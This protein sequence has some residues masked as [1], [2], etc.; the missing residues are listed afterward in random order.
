MAEEPAPHPAAGSE[1][2]AE[3]REEADEETAAFLGAGEASSGWGGEADLEPEAAAFSRRAAVGLAVAIYGPTIVVFVARSICVPVLPLFAR[4]TLG[5]SDS[6]V[7]LSASGQGLGSIFASAGSGLFIGHC[8]YEV[9]LNTGV[10]AM[11]VASCLAGLAQH[12]GLLVL[13][14]VL[15]GCGWS[16]FTVSLQ[17]RLRQAIPGSWRGRAMS[18][19]GGSYRV[20]YLTGPLIGAATAKRLNSLRAVFFLQAAMLVCL[21]AVTTAQ[22]LVGWQRRKRGYGAAAAGAGGGEGKAEKMPYA[23]MLRLTGKDLATAGVACMVIQFFRASRDLVLPLRGDDLNLGVVEVGLVVAC[24]AGADLL[25]FPVS[26]VLMDKFGRK[27]AMVPSFLV[28]ALS[29]ATT[30]FAGTKLTLAFGGV[31][32]G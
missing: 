9:G 3:G 12:V 20:G 6:L 28:F 11:M 8:G 31:L 22:A 13:G 7:G 17:T 18:F 29:M 15:Y 25:F 16:T 30:S 10:A 14:Q 5:A 23:E 26:G 27:S 32:F 21:L 19:M 24:S 1:A 2:G 4:Q